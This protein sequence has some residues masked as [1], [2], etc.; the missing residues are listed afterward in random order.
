M[1]VLTCMVGDG[2]V[3]TMAV[4][5]VGEG[6]VGPSLPHAASATDTAANDRT[7]FMSTLLARES[8]SARGGHRDSIHT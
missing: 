1:V 2:A 5:V 4:T 7:L 3:T 8:V 6:P